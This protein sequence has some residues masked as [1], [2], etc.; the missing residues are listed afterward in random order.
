MGML[1][2]VSIDV[3]ITVVFQF[4]N[5]TL[6]I[7]F[8]HMIIGKPYLKARE[9]REEGTAGSREEADDM[10]ARADQMVIQIEAQMNEARRDAMEVRESL[11]NQGVAEQRDIVDE[12]RGEL[13][14]HLATERAKL[15]GLVKNAQHQLDARAADLAK[16][17]V[18]RVV[19]A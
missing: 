2:A 10:F 3:D 5:F 16:R 8:L 15:D 19:L 17:M 4:V 7:F 12:T 14:D 13:E 11:R 6:A 9:A 1:A 18:D